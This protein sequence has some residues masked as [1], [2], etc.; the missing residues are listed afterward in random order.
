MSDNSIDQRLEAVFRDGWHPGLPI[1]IPEE[2]IYKFS[3]SALQVG[4]FTEDLPGYPPTISP[5]RKRNAKAYLMV[6]RIGS[7]KP[8]T[9]FLWCDADGKPVN[10]WYIQMAEGLVIQDL[11]RDLM[12]M[13]NNQEVSIV[14]TY[15]EELKVMKDRLA[16]RACAL[17]GEPYK[18][19]ADQGW[20]GRDIWFCSEADVELN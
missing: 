2:P 10:K 19:P 12:M 13:Y 6:K 20:D 15:N 8:M 17:K 9:F 5:N 14:T 3:E 16:L 4:H 7:D 11:K 1:P 18:L